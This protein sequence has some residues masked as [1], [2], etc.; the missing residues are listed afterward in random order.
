M[1]RPNTNNVVT[2]AGGFVPRGMKEKKRSMRINDNEPTPIE[3][4]RR[5]QPPQPKGNYA[6]R[7]VPD[8]D[9]GNEFDDDDNDRLPA[10]WARAPKKFLEEPEEENS[11]PPRNSHNSNVNNKNQDWNRAKESRRRNDEDELEHHGKKENRNQKPA[12]N[13]SRQ[14]KYIVREVSNDVEELS[15][16]SAD[17]IEDDHLPSRSHHNDKERNR[18]GHGNDGGFYEYN[19]NKPSAAASGAGDS[20]K[21]R[22][23]DIF[24]ETSKPNSSA[25]TSRSNSNRYERDVRNEE[26]T[27]F[28]A[29]AN[30]KSKEG[31]TLPRKSGRYEDDDDDQPPPRGKNVV[32]NPHRRE[33][34]EEEG[35][36]GEDDDDDLE[37][38][39][40]NAVVHKYHT[41]AKHAQQQQNSRLSQP[42]SNKW[43]SSSSSSRPT[44]PPTQQN[45]I[46]IYNAMSAKQSFV[47]VAHPQGVRTRM[48]QCTI[49][50]ERNSIHGKLYPTYELFL[51]E[52]KKSLIIARK[53]SLNRTSNY[54]LFD[55]TRGA[56]SQNLSKKAGNYLG[57]LRAKSL[58]RTGY[59]LVNNKL[60]GESKEEIA[61]ILFDRVTF[62][63]QLNEGNQPRKMKIVVPLLNED[64]VPIAI[65]SSS[66]YGVESLPEIL[67]NVEDE[68]LALPEDLR[69]LHTK[70][71]V[72]ENGNYRLNFH[73]RVSMPSV[74]NF[75][76]VA[77]DDIEDVKCQF[78]KVERDV[79]HLDYK[80][81][82]NAI[83]AF[84]LALAQF[85]L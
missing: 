35:E 78:G 30:Q 45:L 29:Y 18:G 53:M 56:A 63:D 44:V 9:E 13:N 72:F 69:V 85:N 8:D 4:E 70:D 37:V 7:N 31:I 67:Q 48:V 25:N 2:P 42:D 1:M 55:M 33:V 19:P 22:L 57:K 58:N 11:P 47:H 36:G 39:N 12:T 61:G 65:I 74:K 10:S 71:P 83:Q 73:G 34:A 46:A 82:F 14:Q 28:A 5:K 75:Q 62:L 15:Q 26:E 80:E 38:V 41:G 6:P 76:M 40:L 27:A 59:S 49:V 79:F 81:P 3:H 54:H 32:N 68:K 24:N 64:S 52:P 17:T 21:N 43:F 60:E 77:E 23:R 84:A 66:T 51:E 16:H 20:N 50:R